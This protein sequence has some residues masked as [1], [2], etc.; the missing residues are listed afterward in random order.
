MENVHW[1][2]NRQAEARGRC[3]IAL[4]VS[5]QGIGLGVYCCLQDH[6]VAWIS[7]LG[8]PSIMSLYWFDQ[9][10][11]FIQHGCHVGT[12]PTGSRALFGARHYILIFQKQSGAATQLDQPASHGLQ[13]GKGRSSVVARCSHQNVGVKNKPG[14][15]HITRDMKDS[16]GCPVFS[17]NRYPRQLSRVACHPLRQLPPF[18]PPQ[19]T[20]HEHAHH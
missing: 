13:Q 18:Q 5:H 12:G 7:Q 19:V 6:L 11:Q 9:S 10:G 20:P 4:I 15:F 8:T 2:Q 14:R 17:L 16:K 3:E 1:R